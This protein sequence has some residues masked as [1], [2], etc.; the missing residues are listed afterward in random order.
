M[1]KIPAPGI[2]YGEM[3]MQLY[4]YIDE[5]REENPSM[6]VQEAAERIIE[7]M[8]ELYETR[9]APIVAWFQSIIGDNK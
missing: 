5:M 9:N 7:Y 4:G 3:W 8:D 1:S 2:E 6:P